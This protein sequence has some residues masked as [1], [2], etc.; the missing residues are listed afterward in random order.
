MIIFI[1]SGSP[2]FTIARSRPYAEE[3]VS[4]SLNAAA[5][6]ACRDNA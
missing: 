1:G 5:T 2:D 4:Q 3:N 6:S